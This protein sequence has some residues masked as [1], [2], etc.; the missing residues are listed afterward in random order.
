MV[1]LPGW[2]P[3]VLLL[4]LDYCY[5]GEAMPAGEQ[6]K[7]EL[8]ELL[9]VLGVGGRRPPGTVSLVVVKAEPG[10]LLFDNEE[11]E[12]EEI[13]SNFVHFLAGK[14]EIKATVERKKVA[15]LGD[16]FYNIEM[17]NDETNVKVE[18]EEDDEDRMNASGEEEQQDQI[19]DFKCSH[20]PKSF[21]QK[22][23]WEVNLTNEKLKAQFVFQDHEFKHTGQKLKCQHCTKVF[24][25]PGLRRVHEQVTYW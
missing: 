21:N 8:Q 22:R 12:A 10:Q 7:Q 6:E 4:L 16:N 17:S 5:T 11:E 15:I 2:S 13:N 19:G 24:D 3:G 1:L 20:C 23:K 25:R 18:K 14:H 9:A